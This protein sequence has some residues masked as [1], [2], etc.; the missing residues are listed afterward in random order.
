MDLQK[1]NIFTQGTP[2]GAGGQVLGL[3]SFTSHSRSLAFTQKMP[4]IQECDALTLPVLV[5]DHSVILLV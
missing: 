1:L 2:V 4:C 5:S 3:P